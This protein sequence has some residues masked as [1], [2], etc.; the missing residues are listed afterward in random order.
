MVPL[1][2]SNACTV[3]LWME[4]GVCVGDDAKKRTHPPA[5]T[6]K[7]A[8]LEFGNFLLQLGE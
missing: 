6:P 3:V 2:G 1:M 8:Q 4:E 7:K 5:S